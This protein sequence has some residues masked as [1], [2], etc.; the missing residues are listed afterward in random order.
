[1]EKRR[2]HVATFGCRVNQADSDGIAALLG[3]HDFEPASTHLDA[4]LVVINSCTVTHR[5]DADLR[6][7]VHRVQ[8]D[9]PEAEVIVTGCYAQRAPEAIAALPGVKAVVGTAD[10]ARIGEIALRLVES[11]RLEPPLVVRT[12]VDELGPEE[13]PPIEP[14]ASVQ[15]RTRPF[16]KIQEGCDACCTYCII[17]SV[18]GPARSAPFARIL[19]AVRSLIEQGYFEIVLTGVH[20]GTYGQ[21]ANTSLLTLVRAVLE[22]PGLGRL[23]LSCIEPMAFPLELA[24]LARDDKKLAPHFHLPLQSGSDSVLKRMVRPYRAQDFSDQIAAIKARVPNACVGTDVIVGFPGET[25]ADF[26]DSMRVVATSGVDYAH[27]FSYSDRP[28]VP[29]TRLTGK[30]D[31]RVIKDRASRLIAVGKERW[32]AFLDAQVGR[33]L[34]ALTLSDDG[35]NTALSENYCPIDLESSTSKNR[36]IRARITGRQGDRLRGRLLLPVV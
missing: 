25:E 23:R 6:K 36:S 33:T 7:L 18:R 16:I 20:L 10:T 26:R 21:S 9:N 28:G 1:M 27:V 2:A 22:E 11:K 29:S 35:S 12:A 14:I 17:P 13:L 15:D 4:N 8:R 32:H 3:E 24:D 34:D 30:V 19:T 31:P 5:S